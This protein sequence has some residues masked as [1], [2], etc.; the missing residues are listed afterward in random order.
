MVCVRMILGNEIL[1]RQIVLSTV[2]SGR[3]GWQAD[4]ALSPLKLMKMI[5]TDVSITVVEPDYVLYVP[6]TVTLT[7]SAVSKPLSV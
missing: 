7:L 6:I 2:H 4:A 3:G 1:R 5:P